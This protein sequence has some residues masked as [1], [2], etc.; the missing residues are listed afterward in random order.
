MD[1]ALHQKHAELFEIKKI[2]ETREFQKYIAEPMKKYQDSLAKS[3]DCKTLNE[4]ATLKGKKKGSDKFFE[5]L[6]EIN[7]DFKNTS[8]EIESSD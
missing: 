7:N 5:T 1:K 3:Y 8:F 4:L 6:K 2:I